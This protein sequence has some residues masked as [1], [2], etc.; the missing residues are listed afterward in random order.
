MRSHLQLL[1]ISA[2]LIG[3]SA[4]LNE[5]RRCSCDYHKAWLDIVFVFDSSKEINRQDFYAVR[6]FVSAFV[7]SIPVSQ[8]IGPYSRVGII[9]A[10]DEAFVVGSL[11]AYNNSIDA[12][13]AI[14]GLQFL[15]SNTLNLRSA[16]REAANM[17]N[18]GER[19][20]VKKVVVVF[21]GK[22]EPC[23]YQGMRMKLTKLEEDMNPCRIASQMKTN[24]NVIITI[25]MKF[26]G[27]QR[28]PD[29]RFGSECYTLNFDEAF[30]SN[31]AQAI[32]NANCFCQQPFVQF[33]NKC[34]R[35]GECV[36][37]NGIPVAHSIAEQTC[38]DYGSKLISIFS[39]EKE[40]FV[41]NLAEKAL[42]NNYWLGARK[43]NSNYTW[44]NGAGVDAY[45]NWAPSQP[46][47]TQGNCV[48]EQTL[49]SVGS[50][51]SDVCD[52]FTKT[53]YFSCQVDACDTNNYC[54]ST[55]AFV[56]R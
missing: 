38:S 42:I 22:S 55:N 17:V 24:G 39:L 23:S 18:Y 41:R 4:T 27:L 56:V 9:N 25:G 35:Y 45:T 52:D 26:D 3:L 33:A 43:I 8:Q 15:N 47:A 5:E 34:Q 13:N 21:S 31:F 20:N 54:A 44:P 32:C 46:N 1:G 30:T 37:Q 6:N 12:A 19:P 50:W 40:V 16:M 14:R 53:H 10:G 51:R 29:M 28:F 2:L 49:N 11:K 48:F 7:R 36:Y